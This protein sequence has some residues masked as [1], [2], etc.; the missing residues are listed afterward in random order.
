MKTVVFAIVLLALAIWGGKAAIEATNRKVDE[1]TVAASPN[2]GAQEL[3]GML[4][5]GETPADIAPA[6]GGQ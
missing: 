4:P 2:Q 3:M 5:S 6:A 1:V